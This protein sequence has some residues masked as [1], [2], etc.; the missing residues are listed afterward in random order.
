MANFLKTKYSN[1]HFGTIKTSLTMSFNDLVVKI[2]IW[3]LIKSY[4]KKRQFSNIQ[5]KISFEQISFKKIQTPLFGSR[6]F[7]LVSKLES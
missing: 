5:I 1:F 7:P 6:V 2:L 4:G 3:A